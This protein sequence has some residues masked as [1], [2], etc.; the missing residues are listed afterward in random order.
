V[1]KRESGIGLYGISL[2]IPTYRNIAIGI[3]CRYLR[4][5]SIFPQ[6]QYHDGSAAAPTDN[7]DDEE[8][9]DPERFIGHIAD[10]QAAHSSHI[11]RMI[12]GREAGEQAG[13]TAH[14]RELFWLSST[15]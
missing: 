7:V 13:T 3:S 15:D 14:W 1:L 10:L 11:A 8:G 9:M 12:Y 4:E 6:N 2:N 5:S